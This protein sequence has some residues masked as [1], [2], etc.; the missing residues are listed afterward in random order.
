MRLAEFRT[1]ENYLN[2][3][4]SLSAKATAVI[5]DGQQAI[6]QAVASANRRIDSENAPISESFSLANAMAKILST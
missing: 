5:A 2:Q 1:L 3:R 4:L 6:S